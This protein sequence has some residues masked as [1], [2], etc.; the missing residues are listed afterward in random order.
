MIFLGEQT[1]ARCGSLGFA[2][3]CSISN[4]TV[5]LPEEIL[6]TLDINLTV[7]SFKEGQV[8]RMPEAWDLLES[9]QT[10]VVIAHP[11]AI[12]AAMQT[13]LAQA[14]PAILKLMYFPAKGADNEQ[15]DA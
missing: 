15:T 13:T 2:V 1:T 9:I 5:K 8:Y 10:A 11:A 14:E 12:L 6:Q 4:M 3:A 7:E